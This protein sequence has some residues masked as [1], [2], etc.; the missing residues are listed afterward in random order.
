MKDGCEK[1]KHIHTHVAEEAEKKKGGN[2]FTEKEGK[3]Y[4]PL[5]S[6]LGFLFLQLHIFPFLFVRFCYFEKKVCSVTAVLRVNGKHVFVLLDRYALHRY[7]PRKEK[8]NENTK[9]NK[10]FFFAFV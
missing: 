10:H 1:K 2:N 8:R 6:Y 9:T 4:S 5:R 7:K 3:N